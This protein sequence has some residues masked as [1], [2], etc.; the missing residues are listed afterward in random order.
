MR[1]GTSRKATSPRPPAGLLFDGRF[2]Q[3]GLVAY[4]LAQVAGGL[5]AGLVFYLIASRTLGFDASAGFA[6]N[7]YGEHSPGHYS[8]LARL[9]TEVVMTYMFIMIILGGTHLWSTLRQ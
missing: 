6:A 7:G 1:S 4:I 5:L 9:I 3:A 2:K 8:L